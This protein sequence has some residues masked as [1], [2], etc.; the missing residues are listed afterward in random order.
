M[1]QPAQHLGH[2]LDLWPRRD[3][4]PAQHHHR[5]R[6]IARR[7]D[8]RERGV[9]A[10]VAGHHDVG[11]VIPEHGAVAGPLERPA[12]HDHLGFAQRQRRARRINQPDQIGMLRT[13]SES[14]EMLTADAE[15]HPARA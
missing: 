14:F 6:E 9:A 10:G 7:L 3:H 12:R 5:Q 2:R 11:A 13:A 15:K 8:F 1:T 4:R